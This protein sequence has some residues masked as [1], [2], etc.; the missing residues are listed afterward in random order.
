[1][2]ITQ[3]EYFKLIAENNSLTKA[4]EK[5]HV[6]Q[7]A[8]SLMLKKFEEEVG[9][10]LFDRTA[11][12]I[13]LNS[14]G[15]IALIYVNS[16]LRNVEQMKHDLSNHK[17]N[18]QTLSIAFCDPGIRWYCIPAFP[19][20]TPNIKVTDFLYGQEDE[21]DLL[22][23][24]SYDIVVAPFAI[25]HPEV[26]AI[27][28]L[29]D[30]VYLSVPETSPLAKLTSVSLRDLEAQPFL[31]SDMGGY[32]LRQL[33][34]IITEENPMVTLV[35]NEWLVTQQLIQNTNIL[36][37]SST[38]AI[39]LRNDGSHRVLI[40]LS[41]KE[42]HAIYHICYLRKMKMRVAAFENWAIKCLEL[43]KRQ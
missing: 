37:T 26:K 28:F 11:N 9:V 27:P 13:H 2:D 31:I 12:R 18:N 23:R 14:S 29:E 36:A 39:R 7:P 17:A 21:V 42:Q 41:D 5:L 24:H 8:M 38:L 15:E 1:M 4:A 43:K 22:Q 16:I 30:Q 10:E 25:D 32:F 3:L 40:P 19:A 34:K 20:A 35:K 6:S 33:E